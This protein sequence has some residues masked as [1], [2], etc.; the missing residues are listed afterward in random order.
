MKFIQRVRLLVRGN[1][2]SRAVVLQLFPRSYLPA[3]YILHSS[4]ISTNLLCRSSPL[5]KMHLSYILVLAWFPLTL[6]MPTASIPV[7]RMEL[8]VVDD[9]SDACY[10]AC[11]HEKPNCPSNMVGTSSNYLTQA[12]CPFI[13][14]EAMLLPCRVMR[15]S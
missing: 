12:V 9:R 13:S 3:S 8:E 14:S 6:A 15:L 7:P 1:D 4:P 5:N 10:R 2:I 11:F